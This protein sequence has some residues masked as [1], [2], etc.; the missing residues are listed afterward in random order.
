MEL[1][2]CAAN[3]FSKE[4]SR[5]IKNSIG[6]FI[7]AYTRPIFN[8]FFE[9]IFTNCKKETCELII[10]IDANPSMDVYMEDIIATNNEQC[11]IIIVD[12][13][14]RKKLEKTI[15]ESQRLNAIGEMA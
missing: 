7:S 4:R 6:F 2:Y 5:L 8:S 11:T 1:N 12:I 13:T 15:I 10:A 3:M 9:R 14:E